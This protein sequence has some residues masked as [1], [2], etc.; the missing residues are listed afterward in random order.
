MSTFIPGC[1]HD[2]FVS[3]AHVDNQPIPGAD[4]GWVSTL[5][6]G[7]KVSLGQEL[8]TRNFS[9]WMDNH[10]R[11]N[12]P[13]P[14][15]I[16]DAVTCSTILLIILSKGY[17]KSDWCMRERDAFFESV[18]QPPRSEAGVF[19]VERDKMAKPA[20]FEEISGYRFW[21]DNGED[22]PVRKL[23]YPTPNPNNPDDHPYYSQLDKLS[24][25]LAKELNR[26]KSIA[27]SGNNETSD[28]K[29]ESLD[30]HPAVFLAEVTDD[31]ARQRD[32]VAWFLEQAGVRVFPEKK[33]P[34]DPDAF[35]TA[36]AADLDRSIMFIQL[37]SSLAG[38]KSAGHPDYVRLQYETAFNTDKPVYQWRSPILKMKTVMDAEHLKLLQG[39][40]VFSISFPEFKKEV[41]LALANLVNPGKTPETKQG[42]PFVFINAHDADDS[43]AGKIVEFINQKGLGHILLPNKTQKIPTEI[44]KDFEE[45]ISFCDGVV[46]IYGIA[47]V[48]W[49]RRQLMHCRKIMRGHMKK[50]LAIYEGPPEKKEPLNIGIPGMYTIDCRKDLDEKAFQP[51]IEALGKG[52][53]V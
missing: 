9:L 14:S 15:E 3:Y 2:I 11:C 40:T 12:E 33:Y 20:E 37:L 6:D 43:L 25:D 16:R 23:G 26:L 47:S 42:A 51:F 4:E 44:Q 53:R 52:G 31:L 50:A 41:G 39:D 1:E 35:Q 21:L 28:I 46:V 10:P 45:S 13:L 22:N 38:K 27:E 7:L 29:L 32:K 8:G 48:L 24:Y 30:D 18:R 5:V 49:A 34:G 17:L 36:V 19:I